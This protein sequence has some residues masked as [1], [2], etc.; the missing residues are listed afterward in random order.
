[1]FKCK[2][3]FLLWLY[4]SLFLVYEYFLTNSSLW[5][6]P[7]MN[8]LL[9]ILL[10]EYFSFSMNTSQ[11]ILVYESFSLNASLWM[12]CSMLSRFST[13]TNQGYNATHVDPY[14]IQTRSV[15]GI[16]HSLK[17]VF[18][19]SERWYR[20]IS[21]WI[22]HGSLLILLLSFAHLRKKGFKND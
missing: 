1:L 22:R 3:T 7:Y 5:I 6:L 18:A 13:L 16:Y 21:D 11:W 14:L 4:D 17:G 10:N 9:W 12:M 19:K 2:Y 20:L 8:T 15:T